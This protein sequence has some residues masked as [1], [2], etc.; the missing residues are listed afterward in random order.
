M[1]L[2]LVELLGLVA[3]EHP[4]DARLELEEPLD[5]ARA[6]GPRTAGHEHATTRQVAEGVDG[7]TS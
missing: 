7:P 1:P 2:A 5:E 4:D 6:D 3:P